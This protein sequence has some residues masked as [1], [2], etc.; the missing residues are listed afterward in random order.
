ME[1]KDA[2]KKIKEIADSIEKKTFSE[3][4]DEIKDRLPKKEKRFNI[5]RWIAVAASAC[6]LLALAILLPIFF[7]PRTSVPPET[8][9]FNLSE[10][11]AEAVTKDEF[12]SQ[13]NSADLDIIDVSELNIEAYQLA[14]TNDNVIRGGRLFFE[15]LEGT[16]EYMFT[17]TFYDKTV[18]FEEETRYADL[19]Q[20]TAVNGINIR[21]KTE[22]TDG[23]YESVALAKYEEI[24]YIIE[25]SS[26]NMDAED[27][28]NTVF[29]EENL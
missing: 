10:I 22:E 25:Y 15:N 5:K 4:W 21:Y 17:I 29:A 2:E 19:L 9:Y 26:L 13:L 18:D 1:N 7:S 20:N 3:C 28:F 27:F 6:S 23:I 12:Y 8:S 11:L 16:E 14:K 24:S